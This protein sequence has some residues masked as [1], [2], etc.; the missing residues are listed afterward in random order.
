VWGGPT[1]AARPRRRGLRLGAGVGGEPGDRP[2][3]VD[4]ERR[5]PADRVG[6]Q[7]HVHD[8]RIAQREVRV[9][10]GRLGRVG[11][12]RHQCSSGG[13]RVEHELGMDRVLVDAP[14]VESVERGDVVRVD[15]RVL[16]GHE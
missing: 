1:D 2:G 14:V 4:V 12:R 11:D 15:A 16:H 6:G 7:L 8:T 5:Q 10:N 9:M 13:E 3:E